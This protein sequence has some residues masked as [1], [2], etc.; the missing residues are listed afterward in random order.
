MTNPLSDQRR[1]HSSS[2]G[3]LA[4]QE[5]P[6]DGPEIEQHDFALETLRRQWSRRKP[7]IRRRARNGRVLPEQFG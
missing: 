1:C 4:A 6:P 7:T 3:K 5:L 2:F